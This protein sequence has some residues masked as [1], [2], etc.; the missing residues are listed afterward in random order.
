M[1][2]LI[3]SKLKT[4]NFV[5]LS[6]SICYMKRVSV[7]L[8]NPQIYKDHLI[9]LIGTQLMNYGINPGCSYLEQYRLLSQETCISR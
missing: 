4:A 5:G 8:L 2:S 9:Q 1:P 3:T 7:V 6:F